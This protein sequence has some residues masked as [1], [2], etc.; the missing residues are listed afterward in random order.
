MLMGPISMSL[1]QDSN[2]KTKL[3][4]TITSKKWTGHY[5]LEP[6][7]TAQISCTV[8]WEPQNSNPNH[9]CHFQAY[10]KICQQT[11]AHTTKWIWTIKHQIDR[12]KVQEIIPFLQRLSS[13]SSRWMMTFRPLVFSFSFSYFF[14]HSSAVSSMFTETV[15]LMV[16]ALCYGEQRRFNK[17]NYT[18]IY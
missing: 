9:Y 16:L 4:K 7:S 13:F 17:K 15:F 18:W 11:T 1:F 2:L 12:D 5:N 6:N 3:F 10:R 14:F 8:S